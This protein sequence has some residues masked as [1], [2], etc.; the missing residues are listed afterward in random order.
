MSLTYHSKISPTGL[1]GVMAINRAL[2]Q[3]DAAID[4]ISVV[5]DSFTAAVV[6]DSKATTVDGG[7]N[8]GSSWIQRALNA[9]SDPDNIVALASNRFTPIAGTYLVFAIAPAYDVDNHK[10]RLKNYTASE[11]VIATGQNADS[12]GS[13]SMVGNAHLAAIFTANGTDAYQIEHW[14]ATTN[15]D[16][17]FGIATD[18]G[19]V[20][21]YTQVLLLRFPS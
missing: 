4:A 2:A 13:Q 11:A 1:I 5:N 19:A 17:G 20:E 21:I 15:A 16:D 10:I 6:Y 12:K 8:T 3:L 9:E 7:S 14:T 18:D